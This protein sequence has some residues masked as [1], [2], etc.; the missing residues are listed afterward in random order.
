M[1][2]N[3][4]ATLIMLC[5]VVLT[6][7]SAI[8]GAAENI[9]V[10]QL[11]IYELNASTFSNVPEGIYAAEARTDGSV[12]NTS[13]TYNNMLHSFDFVKTKTNHG[14][15]YIGKLSPMTD[16]D[17][18]IDLGLDTSSTWSELYSYSSVSYLIIRHLDNG[19]YKV[20]SAWRNDTGSLISTQ[21][22]TVPASAITNNHIKIHTTSYNDNRTNV[23]WFNDTL[24][25]S[26]PYRS[27]AVRA[28]N[29]PV[30]IQPMLFGE[31]SLSDSAENMTVHIYSV[32]QTI[33]RKTVTVYPMNNKMG[34][35]IDGPE[36][37][38][39]QNGTA[40]MSANGQVGTVW[41]GNDDDQYPVDVAYGKS[42]LASGWE[43]GIHFSTPL[44]SLS[45]DN[46]YKLIDDEVAA[47]TAI[48]GQAPTSWCSQYDADNESHALYCYQQHGMIWRNG[49]SGVSLVSNVGNLDND[50]WKWWNATASNGV[51][52]PTYTHQIDVTSPLTIKYSIDAEKFIAF[53]DKYHSHGVNLV[54]FTEYYKNG[55]SQNT[56]SVTINE[57]GAKH[58]NFTIATTGTDSK[59]ISVYT[60]IESPIVYKNG[61][62]VASTKTA[63]GVE[64]L[65]ANGEYTIM[66]SSLPPVASFTANVTEGSAPLSVQFNDSSINADTVNWDFGDGN[67]STERNPIH[68]YLTPGTYTVNLTAIN[69]NGTDSKLAT[70]SVSEK[71]AAVLPVS[72]FSTNVTEGSAPLTVQ[73]NDSSRNATSVNW[74]FGDG[75]NSTERNPIHK[76]L[77]PGTYTVNLTAI[78]GNGTD[79][80]LAT[81]TVSSAITG[82]AENIDVGQLKIYELNASTFSNVP[83]GIY[84]AEART[85]VSVCNTSVTYNNTLHSFDF[86]K[87]KTNYGELYIGKLSPMTDGDIA[88]DLGLDTSSTWSELYIYSSVSYLIIRHLD[89]GGYKVVSAWKNDTGSLISTQAF[90]VPAS[91]ITNNHIKIHTTSYNDNRTNVVWFNDTLRTS[92]PY[93]SKAVR[94]L[95]YPVM[96]QPILFGEVYLSDSAE[97][98]TVHIYSVEQTIPRKTVTVYPI[99][100]KMGVGIDGPELKYT[101]NGTA[102]MS[103]NGQVGTV[104]AGNDD[105]QYPVD[106]AYGKSLLASGWELGIHFSTPLNS[107]SLDNSYKLIDDEV[108]AVTAIYGQAPTSWCSQSDADNES[109]ALYCYQQH[110]MIW[111]NGPSGVSLVSNVGNL[112]NDTWKWWN[113]TASNGVVYPTYT[114]QIDVTS[115][116]TIK[117]SIDAEKFIA[118][119]DK[120]HSHGVNLVGFTE[121]YKNGISQNT[122]SVTINEED[123]KH[124][125][126]TIA[127]TGTDSKNISV[128]TAIESPIVYKN[129]VVVAS[130]KTADGVEFLGANGEYTIMDSSLPP[131][132][133]FTA[134]VTE[135]SAPLSVQFN[136]SSMN[137][138][139]VNW[140]F[141]DGNNSTERNPIHKYLTPGTYTV[142]LTATNGNGTD[143]KL[144]TITVSEKPAAV[145]PV[146]NFSTNVTE[147]YAPSDGPV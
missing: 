44:N 39:T 111:R 16:G 25:T 126:F 49:P 129:G 23:V 15:L 50:T 113:A 32:E 4:R 22:F 12:C 11:K 62:V 95:N 125:N 3:I 82:P 92:S 70:I 14:E 35:G 27:K 76:Y 17:I 87:T 98:M 66:D 75:N 134:N 42:L 37:K 30:M 132:A 147:G 65:G 72:N 100:N 105:D 109:H 119:S 47:V 55:I 106:V 60:A 88:I 41:A 104:W 143:S 81:I 144:A 83:E 140:D 121:Y 56:S 122:S 130:T 131:V 128:Y 2:K 8:T 19:G 94:A 137:A 135:G 73:F 1:M 48:Y 7:S 108:A 110:G 77:T 74:D 79:S 103:A 146:S 59:N 64:F 53:S 5:L 133:S 85:D 13:V 28:L 96:I 93:R 52:Y 43:L 40:H 38:Y 145:L 67:N 116:L 101:Q 84:A 45:L 127:T 36:L 58:M 115:P 18:A 120:Y 34:V 26:S 63:D 107:L 142:N 46:S 9:D 141:G 69:G 86:V 139:T 114:H 10:G 118:F 97:N 20:V 99:N 29:Y 91:A 24:R 31:V 6:I 33:P 51:V 117:Y 123:A 68:K 102:H 78:N 61:V 136:D 138:D 124:M 80:K 90:T 71:P 54:G 21:A 112:D 89:N 57:E